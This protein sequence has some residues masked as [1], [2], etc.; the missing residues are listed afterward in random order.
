MCA[1]ARRTCAR[2]ARTA[3][4]FLRPTATQR[5]GTTRAIARRVR[6]RSAQPEQSHRH[7]AMVFASRRRQATCANGETGALGGGYAYPAVL[8]FPRP[9]A[10]QCVVTMC[11]IP[12]RTRA[13]SAR[14][15]LEFLELTARQRAGTTRA[16]ARRVRARSAQPAPSHRHCAK[17]CAGRC[18]RRFRRRRRRSRRPCQSTRAA[19]T[20]AFARSAPKGRSRP[21]WSARNRACSC[22]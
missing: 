21:G 3:L 6:V 2:S 7:C 13:R 10:K 19:R 8:E 18:Q 14:A 1:I 12:R 4:G 16:I 5:A 20:W 15:A 17:V 22:A 9:T 11:A